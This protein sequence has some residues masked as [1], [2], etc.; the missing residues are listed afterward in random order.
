LIYDGCVRTWGPP[1][2]EESIINMANDVLTYV[3]VSGLPLSF[4]IEWPFHKSVSGADF[5][6]LHGDMRLEDG[7]GL[8]CLW[9]VHLSAVMV[10]QFPSLEAQHTRDVVIN[11]LR[12]EVETKQLEFLKASKR[13][14]VPLS[15][16]FTNFKTKAWQFM[17]PTDDETALFLRDKIYWL[18]QSGIERVWIADPCDAVYVGRTT[19]QLIDI[20]NTLAATGLVTIDGAHATATDALR[21]MSG[22]IEAR[23]KKALEELQMKHAYEQAAAVKK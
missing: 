2:F 17:Q 18:G 5:Q 16:R 15:S 9:A 19:A 8:H 13:Q 23:E 3:T 4:T 20:A 7:S 11:A 6:V 22:E 10:G 12:K 21:G 1:Q 14:P